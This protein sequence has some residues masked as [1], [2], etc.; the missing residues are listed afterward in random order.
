MLLSAAMTSLAESAGTSTVVNR[1]EMSIAPHVGAR[2]PSLIGDGTDNILWADTGV[3]AKPDVDPLLANAGLARML[4]SGMLLAPKSFRSGPC[5]R[6]PFDRHPHGGRDPVCHCRHAN[7]F[8]RVTSCRPM[9]WQTLVVGLPL[10]RLHRRWRCGPSL[11]LP[12]P[13]DQSRT[14]QSVNPTPAVLIEVAVTANALKRGTR[15]FESP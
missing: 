13:P 7:V 2:Q 12:R 10:R 14:P 1:D 5:R 6:G 3:L 4:L 15:E 9:L 11:W 8:R